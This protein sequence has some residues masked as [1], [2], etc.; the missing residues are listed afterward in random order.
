MISFKENP[1]KRKD[2][3]IICILQIFL[4]LSLPQ[5]TKTEFLLTTLIPDKAG[6]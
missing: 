6:R 2:Y 4:T 5:E 3:G 1:R